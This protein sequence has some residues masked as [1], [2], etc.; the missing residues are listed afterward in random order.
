MNTDISKLE[1]LALAP[2]VEFP[3]TSRAI[4]DVEGV[5]GSGLWAIVQLLSGGRFKV[6]NIDNE[7]EVVA[8]HSLLRPI[9]PDR[10]LAEVRKRS[11][12]TE[13]PLVVLGDGQ[14]GVQTSREPRPP[15]EKHPAITDADFDAN[16]GQCPACIEVRR[17]EHE[18]VAR[19]AKERAVERDRQYIQALVGRARAMYAAI[20]EATTDKGV[21]YGAEIATA[22]ACAL[23]IREGLD[24]VIDK[25][26]RIETNTGRLATSI[27]LLE[28]RH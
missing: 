11:G 20:R 27:D 14:G 18:E 15:C 26:D 1:E 10:V 3:Q 19:K 6:R 8:H 17:A 21:H 28:G 24:D 25:L 12:E 16:E 5:D 22:L 13:P 23:V 2:L 4:L 7:T 9:A